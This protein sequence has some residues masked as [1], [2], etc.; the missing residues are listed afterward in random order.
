MILLKF[1]GVEGM[2]LYIWDERPSKVITI[3]LPKDQQTLKKQT[4]EPIEDRIGAMMCAI[5]GVLF[6]IGILFVIGNLIVT[7]FEAS[8]PP[9][10]LFP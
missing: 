9:K 2:K 7:F 8:P 5:W 4:V 10:K 1:N 3:S 6:I